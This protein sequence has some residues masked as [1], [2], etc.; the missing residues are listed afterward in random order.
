VVSSCVCVTSGGF[1]FLEKHS[2]NSV[3]D[4]L[5]QF[6]LSCCRTLADPAFPHK[7]AFEFMAS[8]SS[9]VWWEM[10]IRKERYVLLCVCYSA[11]SPYYL[12]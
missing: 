6:Q 7:M 12:M 2:I 5:L 10:N 4:V 3:M 8:F 9:S 11:I 1:L